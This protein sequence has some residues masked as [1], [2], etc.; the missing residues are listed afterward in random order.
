MVRWR[1]ESPEDVID[2][3]TFHRAERLK[4]HEA[5]T[6][7]EMVS[8]VVRHAEPVRKL[9]RLHQWLARQRAERQAA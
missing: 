5:R 4:V 8:A 3:F 6:E 7:A 9:R 2:V 1:D